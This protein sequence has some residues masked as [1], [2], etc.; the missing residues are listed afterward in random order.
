MSMRQFLSEMPECS[1]NVSLH[2]SGHTEDE[3]TPGSKQ[4]SEPPQFLSFKSQ[5]ESLKVLPEL[6]AGVT[7]G[8]ERGPLMSHSETMSDGVLPIKWC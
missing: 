3:V 8:E 4:E 1:S 7:P 5:V 6:S 2:V